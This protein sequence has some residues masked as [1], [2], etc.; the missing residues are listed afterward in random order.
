MRSNYWPSAALDSNRKIPNGLIPY[1]GDGRRP[2][3]EGFHFGSAFPP[4]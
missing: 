1:L 4:L 2:G 3:K